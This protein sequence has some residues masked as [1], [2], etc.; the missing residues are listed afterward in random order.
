LEN[1]NIHIIPDLLKKEYNEE[2]IEP[3]RKNIIIENIQK[4]LHTLK[5]R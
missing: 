3:T 4:R 5:G 1:K 2:Y